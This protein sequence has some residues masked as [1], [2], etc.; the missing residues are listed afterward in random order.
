MG[1]IANWSNIEDGRTWVNDRTGYVLTI[2]KTSEGDY[3]VVGYHDFQQGD[4]P[5]LSDLDAEENTTIATEPT[6]ES[7]RTV[8]REYMGFDRLRLPSRFTSDTWSQSLQL[9]TDGSQRSSEMPGEAFD[10]TSKQGYANSVRRIMEQELKLLK[11]SDKMTF[12]RNEEE[13]RDVFG[14]KVGDRYKSSAEWYPTV[15]E[16]E[17]NHDLDQENVS[18]GGAFFVYNE[19]GRRLYAVNTDI[20]TRKMED[21]G[22]HY[23]VKFV[24]E[25]DISNIPH[26]G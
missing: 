11:N 12:K 15:R 3:D 16:A 5:R 26:R 14:V 21:G 17:E 1:R 25:Q 20:Q 24:I 7:A 13:N 22:R 4:L 18:I 6:L 2:V 23:Y 8:A 10:R 9:G 19:E